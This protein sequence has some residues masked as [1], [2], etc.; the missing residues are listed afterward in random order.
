MNFGTKDYQEFIEEL[1]PIVDRYYHLDFGEQDCKD[2]I[3]E[4]WFKVYTENLKDDPE[5]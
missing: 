2:A 1:K 5:L 3:A 4:A